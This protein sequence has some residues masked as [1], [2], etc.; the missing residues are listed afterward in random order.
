MNVRC[1]IASQEHKYMNMLSV[2]GGTLYDYSG[3]VS[4]QLEHHLSIHKSRKR[5]VLSGICSE[6]LENMSSM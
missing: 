5:L 3:N 1:I 6:L 2:K 4:R